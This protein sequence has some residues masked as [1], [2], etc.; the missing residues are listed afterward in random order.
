M[1]GGVFVDG[2][3]VIYEYMSNRS[4]FIYLVTSVK[5]Y[6]ANKIVVSEQYF[7]ILTTQ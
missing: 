5:G 2:H 4:Y 1:K 7:D 6:S 3:R